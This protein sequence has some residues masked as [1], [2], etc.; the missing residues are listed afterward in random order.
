[1]QSATQLKVTALKPLFIKLNNRTKAVE[2][3]M[4]TALDTKVNTEDFTAALDT[5]T[6]DASL[7]AVAKSGSYGDLLNIPSPIDTNLKFVSSFDGK[8]GAVKSGETRMTL[9]GCGANAGDFIEFALI[10]AKQLNF[11][12]TIELNESIKHYTILNGFVGIPTSTTPGWVTVAPNAQDDSFFAMDFWE[13]QIWS[14]RDFT[15]LRIRRKGVLSFNPANYYVLF[16]NRKQNSGEHFFQQKAILGNDLTP[17]PQ[18]F[19]SSPVVWHE[20]KLLLDPK[21]RG[22]N[23]QTS[24]KQLPNSSL[25]IVGS[26][27]APIRATATNTTAT[28]D[29]YTIICDAMNNSVTVTLPSAATCKGRIYNVRKSDSSANSIIV[30]SE[31]TTT[32]GTIVMQSDGAAWQRIN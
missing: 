32:K 8:K 15:K 9:T 28:D 10:Q 24:A 3:A 31:T 6:N 12:L 22:A 14:D 17:S 16:K 19:S 23:Y 21:Y 7:S 18:L 1:V 27:S 11:D 4:T 26:F 29:D 2:A 25:Q 5:K 13:L 30:G 20:S